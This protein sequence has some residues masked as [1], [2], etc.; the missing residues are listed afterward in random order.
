MNLRKKK[1]LKTRKVYSSLHTKQIIN[2]VWKEIIRK[3]DQIK[4]L[5]QNLV[6]TKT[7]NNNDYSLELVSSEVL[8]SSTK[9]TF[10]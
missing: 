7:I 5:D 2:Q 10:E 4:E 6:I 1:L 8:I 9:T 3:L